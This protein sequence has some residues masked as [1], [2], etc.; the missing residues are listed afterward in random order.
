MSRYL[1]LSFIIFQFICVDIFILSINYENELNKINIFELTKLNKINIYELTK[2]T[3][4]NNNDLNTYD[5]NNCKSTYKN[6]YDLL[7]NEWIR[8]IIDSEVIR[9]YEISKRTGQGRLT[10]AYNPTKYKDGLSNHIRK[11]IIQKNK[12]WYFKENNNL[13][14][15]HSNENNYL[16]LEE[17][18]SILN[19]ISNYIT[20]IYKW[21]NKNINDISTSNQYVNGQGGGGAYVTDNTMF[22]KYLF[23]KLLNY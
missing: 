11:S 12:E 3:K 20:L 7:N 5:L 23:M 2:L 21:E 13:Y 1:I 15:I 14:K 22:M 18:A 17:S 4:L 8:N 10:D 16:Y 19:I 6:I 9:V